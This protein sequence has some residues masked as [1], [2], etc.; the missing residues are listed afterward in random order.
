M[1]FTVKY[2][3]LNTT[4][5]YK[6]QRFTS[7]YT[8]LLSIHLQELIDGSS[9]SYWKSQKKDRKPVEKQHESYVSETMHIVERVIDE[10]RL[11]V[12]TVVWAE[13]MGERKYFLWGWKNKS[14]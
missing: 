2:P 4:K 11:C 3:K 9:E 13:C 14:T 6:L 5:D 7:E 8:I 1:I 10:V 12:K